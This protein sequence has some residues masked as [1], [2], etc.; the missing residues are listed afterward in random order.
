MTT[1]Q[2]DYLKSVS[3]PECEFRVC[4]CLA[5][6]S[7]LAAWD[8]VGAS[9]VNASLSAPSPLPAVCWLSPY[10]SKRLL[11]LSLILPLTPPFP[12]APGG[13]GW[14]VALGLLAWD[15]RSS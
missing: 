12:T 1:N 3:P 15:P 14:A 9:G 8:V 5:R 6:C 7:S 11:L 10:S 2:G 13:S 4:F